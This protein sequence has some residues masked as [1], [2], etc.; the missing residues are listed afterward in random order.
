M[1]L[2][3]D[4]VDSSFTNIQRVVIG[5]AIAATV[6]S[7]LSLVVTSQAEAVPAAGLCTTQVDKAIELLDESGH[8]E[9]S[10]NPSVVLNDLTSAINSGF[11]VGDAF[12]TAETIQVAIERDC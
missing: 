2:R 7:G 10:T 1:D 8:H 3:A 9:S 4:E 5:A 11:F 6:A 12:E